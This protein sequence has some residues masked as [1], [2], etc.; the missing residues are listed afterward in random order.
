MKEKLD[1]LMKNRGL[2]VS[3]LA[4]MLDIQPSGVS[5]LLSGRNKPS[6]DLVQ[7][8]LRTFP[9]V[10]PDWLLLDG[11]IPFRSGEAAELSKP[12]LSDVSLF[13]DRENIEISASNVGEKN[14]DH[15]IFALPQKGAKGVE[16][17]VIFYADGSFDSYSPR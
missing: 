4:R 14:D 2:T 5:H 13:D 12:T 1:F 11:D 3:S 16:R 9:D 8:I 7:K 10:N 15:S 6:F 17:I